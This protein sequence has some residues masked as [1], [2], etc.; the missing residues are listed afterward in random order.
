MI[1][2][3]LT[4]NN[5]SLFGGGISPVTILGES[6]LAWWTADRADLITLSGTQVTSWKDDVW[7]DLR[8]SKVALTPFP[9]HVSN[10]FIDGPMPSAE[11]RVAFGVSPNNYPYN[12][13]IHEFWV[14]STR[15][16]RAYPFSP[17]IT[18]PQGR[19]VVVCMSGGKAIAS[20][21]WTEEADP[22]GP[23]EDPGIPVGSLSGTP[24]GDMLNMGNARDGNETT[25]ATGNGDTT[26]I[27]FG[28]DLG[29][30]NASALS[31]FVLRSPIG[32][33]FCGATPARSITWEHFYSADAVNWTAGPT[34]SFTDSAGSAQTILD[35]TIT[36]A[37]ARAHR[38]RLSNAAVAGW[39]LAEAAFYG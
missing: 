1:G 14:G 13:P 2:L 33:S 20:F 15:N 18:I 6:L 22:L 4:I 23:V 31:R 5:M 21:Q 35:Q 7:G 26:S 17:A 10:K 27:T 39:R 24:I 25:Y 16:D 3:A 12:R 36:G 38:V 32:R 19:G 30:G 29:S 34:G 28:I 11:I 9:D 37:S 8:K